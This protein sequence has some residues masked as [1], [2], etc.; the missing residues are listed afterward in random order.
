MK[1][2]RIGLTGGIGAGKS[3]ALGE[4]RRAGAATISLDEIT[5][6]LS[7]SGSAGWRRV[8]AAFGPGVLDRRGEIDRPKLAAMIFSNPAK[9]RRLEAAMHPLI[10]REM[11]RRMAAAK[12]GPLVVDVP[13]LFEAGL[14]RRFDLTMLVTAPAGLRT[15]R[16]RLGSSVSRQSTISERRSI[17]LPCWKSAWNSA[18]VISLSRRGSPRS[19]R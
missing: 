7:R 12:A 2:L 5:H 17:R 19:R 6:D 11:E 4:F 18:L 3:L 13:L 16:L 9:R 8:R 10:L 14:E 15:R 1:K